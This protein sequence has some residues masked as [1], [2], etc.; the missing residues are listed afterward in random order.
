[1]AHQTRPK[2]LRNIWTQQSGQNDP[3][4]EN[5]AAAT[6]VAALATD[7]WCGAWGDYDRDGQVDLLV[8]RALGAKSNPLSHTPPD[9]MG[10]SNRLLR[11]RVAVHGDF[12]DRSVSPH[13]PFCS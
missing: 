12:A 1:V 10:A 8:G 13:T 11:N 4:F 6:G 3:V 7:S 9:L 5:T 2:L